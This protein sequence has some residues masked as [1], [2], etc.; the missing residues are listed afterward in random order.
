MTT[1]SNGQ[2][3]EYVEGLVESVNERGLRLAGESA[4][5]NFSRWAGAIAGP[6]KGQRV[7]LALDGSGFVRS[8]EVLDHPARSS[9]AASAA[10]ER[11]IVRQA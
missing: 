4:W 8:V 1:S 10:R 3:A 5:R 6:S 7:R 2:V 9:P 11:G